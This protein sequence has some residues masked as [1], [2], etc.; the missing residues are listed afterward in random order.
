MFISILVILC[1]LCALIELH[2]VARY[3]EAR[4]GQTGVNITQETIL[5]NNTFEGGVEV[6]KVEVLPYAYHMLLVLVKDN[7]KLASELVRNYGPTSDSVS[8]RHW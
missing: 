8:Y 3:R 2:V 7:K 1:G 5:Y 4:T 6:P